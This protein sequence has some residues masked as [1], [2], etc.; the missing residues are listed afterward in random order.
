[1]RRALKLSLACMLLAGAL[2]APAH[3]AP[4]AVYVKLTSGTDGRPVAYVELRGNAIRVAPSVERLADAEAIRASDTG[5]RRD[6]NTAY[7]HSTFP[8]VDLPVQV[9]QAAKVSATFS[10]WRAVSRGRSRGSGT[11]RLSV[12]AEISL[13]THGPAGAAWTYVFSSYTEASSATH[14]SKAAGIAIPPLGKLQL[15][16]EIQVKGKEAGIGLR[17]KSGDVVLSQARRNGE[18][19]ACTLEIYDRQGQKVSTHKG[20]LQK[21]GFT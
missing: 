17:L 21:F 5:L 8:S 7:Q 15:T 6:G 1:M 16:M 13:T 2:S 4:K 14:P 10:V 3:A 19:A 20:D 11:E 9:P 18:A 12:S